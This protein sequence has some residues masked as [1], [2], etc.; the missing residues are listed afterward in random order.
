MELNQ[1]TAFMSEIL[2]QAFPYKI[3]LIRQCTG[4]QL[5]LAD[6]CSKHSHN[7]MTSKISEALWCMVNPVQF[8]SCC[9]S[10]CVRGNRIL[11]LQKLVDLSLE[12]FLWASYLLPGYIYL[13]WKLFVRIFLLTAAQSAW[14]KKRMW[15]GQAEIGKDGTK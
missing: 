6:I 14:M 3:D 9:S 5:I 2:L 15:S 12:L 1:N 7:T 4:L 11:W 10:F 13:F 8:F